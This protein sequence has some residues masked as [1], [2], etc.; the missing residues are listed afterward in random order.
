MCF[1]NPK[2]LDCE[3]LLEGI[4]PEVGELANGLRLNTKVLSQNL[5]RAWDAVR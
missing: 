4:I 5:G 3:D 2:G 1:A